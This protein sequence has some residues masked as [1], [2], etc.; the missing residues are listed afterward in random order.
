MFIPV[1]SNTALFHSKCYS[2]Y[3]LLIVSQLWFSNIWKATKNIF[4]L[5]IIILLTILGADSPLKFNWT[6]KWV[7]PLIYHE[8]IF[9]GLVVVVSPYYGT[10]QYSS[11]V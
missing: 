9:Q 3:V 10:V 5:I 7:H 8:I 4:V 11:N 2:K 1:I 6:G